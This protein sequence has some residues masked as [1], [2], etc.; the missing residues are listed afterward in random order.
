MDDS[1]RAPHSRWGNI[2]VAALGATAVD[3]LASNS[4]IGWLLAQDTNEAGGHD[5]FIQGHP[6]YDRDD[7]R[8][9]HTRDAGSRQH[10]PVGYYSP[11]GQ[12]QLTWANDARALH[13]NWINALYR[14]FSG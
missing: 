10:E 11:D 7:L 4:D 6:E 13:D 2:P 1:I 14:H 9:E 12:P 5:V 8:I 3:V